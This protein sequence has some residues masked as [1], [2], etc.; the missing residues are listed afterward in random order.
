MEILDS[1]NENEAIMI[2][3]DPTLFSV[4]MLRKCIGIILKGVE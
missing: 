2:R 4:K 3:V 1:G